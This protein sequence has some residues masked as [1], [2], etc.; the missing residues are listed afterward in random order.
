MDDTLRVGFPK[1]CTHLAGDFDPLSD[2]QRS[3][4]A[5]DTT[6]GFALNELHRNEGNIAYSVELVHSANILVGDLAG[7]KEFFLQPLNGRSVGSNLGPKNL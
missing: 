2:T 4:P 5:Q 3:E 6:Q 7:Q 1:A